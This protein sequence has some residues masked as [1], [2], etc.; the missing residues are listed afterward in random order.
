MQSVLSKSFGGLSRPYFIRQLLFGLIFPAMTV[1]A[2][3]HG[4]RPASLP[5]H[6]VVALVVNTLLYPYA[7]FVYEGGVSYIVGDHFF[8]VPTVA[9][10]FFKGLTMAMCWALAIF[11]APVGL[12]YLYFR[13]SRG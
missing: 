10:V 8:I 2:F 1:F 9:L 13:H 6:L 4:S 5:A 7:R 12:I 3:T 11:I